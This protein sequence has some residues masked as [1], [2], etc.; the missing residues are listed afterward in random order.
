MKNLLFSLIVFFFLVV[1]PCWGQKPSSQKYSVKGRWD[2]KASYSRQLTPRWEEPA[3]FIEYVNDFRT[4]RRGSNFRFEGNYG[5]CNWLEVGLYAGWQ[6][7]RTFPECVDVENGWKRMYWAPTFGTQARIHLL[8][9]F[10]KDA[11]CRWEWYITAHYG[12][13]YLV[14]PTHYFTPTDFTY[15]EE[16]Y[17]KRQRHYRHEYGVGMGGGVYFWRLFGLFAEASVGQFSFWPE[18]FSYP[19][20]FRAGMSFKF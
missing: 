1:S 10:V 19:F 17:V 5:V 2:I 20:N 12:G 3:V 16:F 9:F 13:C 4:P 7:Y 15:S 6:N 18:V 8:P 11:N 14:H